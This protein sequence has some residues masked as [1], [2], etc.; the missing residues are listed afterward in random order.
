ML[1]ESVYLLVSEHFQGRLSEV[2][3]GHSW[4]VL[5][6]CNE[7]VTLLQVRHLCKYVLGLW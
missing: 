2:N 4:F 5:L 6:D 1:A 3:S 7:D